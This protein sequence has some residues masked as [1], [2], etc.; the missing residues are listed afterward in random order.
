MRRPAPEEREI[1][2]VHRLSGLLGAFVELIYLDVRTTPTA[3]EW[4]LP[5]G[6]TDLLV[7][8]GDRSGSARVAG[9]ACWEPGS[10]LVSGP[11]TRPFLLES[12]TRSSTLGVVFR[13]GGAAALLGIAPSATRDAHVPLTEFWG[14]CAVDFGA[15][16]LAAGDPARQLAAVERLL[17]ARLADARNR[18]PPL[19]AAAQRLSTDRPKRV[20]QVSASLGISQRRMEQVFASGLGLTPKRYQR[21]Q[22]FRRALTH[23]ESGR[24]VGFASY[25]LELGYYDQAH[26]NNEFRSHAGMS[27]S[28]YLAARRPHRNHVEADSITVS[29]SS[30]LPR[31]PDATLPP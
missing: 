9:G 4:L 22:R 21:L 8:L 12:A 17:S 16:V 11:W 5:R 23:L 18:P 25:A 13:L 10:V 29:L 19:L 26:F 3:R 31:G 14:P 20:A 24:E 1:A 7:A 15:R 27:P 6:T 2:S 30:K 28:R